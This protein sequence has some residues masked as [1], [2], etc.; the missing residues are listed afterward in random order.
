MDMRRW[1]F[2]IVIFTAT[3]VGCGGGGGGK[4]SVKTRGSSTTASSLTTTSTTAAPSAADSLAAYFE[5]ADSVH[6]KL[7]AAAIKINRGFSTSRVSFDQA[8]VDTVAAADPA[9]AAILIPPGLDP[10]L[11]RAVLLTQSELVSRHS[12]MVRVRVGTF[13]ANGADAKDLLRCLGLGAKAAA[14]FPTDLASA[15]ALAVSTPPLTPASND[16]RAA[17]ELAI[18]LQ[19]ITLRNRGCDSCGGAVL[20]ELLPIVWVQLPS[21]PGVPPW[22]GSI[23]GVPF[24]AT[25]DAEGWHIELNA[26]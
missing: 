20:T 2:V 19:D 17:A 5:A 1:M 18:R 7:A 26:C 8:T 15:R 21:S 23:G 9:P 10:A 11:L 16:S 12:A 4:D 6:R 14:R 22:D 3:M 24:R 25:H 13:P